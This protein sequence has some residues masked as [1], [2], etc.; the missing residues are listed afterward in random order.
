MRLIDADALM[1]D[2]CESLNQMTNI[3]ISVDGEWL[4]GKLN[5]AFEHAP[6]IEERKTG[7][8][9]AKD[10]RIKSQ[11]FCCS[12]CGGVAYQPWRGCRYDRSKTICRFKFCPNCGARMRESDEA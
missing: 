10:E 3:G 9:I 6:T 1:E 12:V 5:D 7:K 8:W 11:R 4:W 2:I